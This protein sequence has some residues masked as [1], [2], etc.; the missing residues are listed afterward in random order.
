MSYE[1]TKTIRGRDYRYKVESYRDPQTGK[2]RNRWHYLGKGHGEAPPRRRAQAGETRAKL[3]AALERL[4][5]REPWSDVT[6]L[7]IAAEAG[8]TAATLYRY[9]KS[10]D[11][12]LQAC[13]A[14]AND[15]LDR[16]LAQLHDVASDVDAERARLRA[17][18]IA[19]AKN[20]PGSAVLL[21]LSSSSTST[22]VGRDRNL[23]RRRGFERYFEVLAQRGF[24]ATT[25]A[26]RARL[27]SALTFFA[28]AF[29]Y[30]VV[31]ARTQMGDD[32][33]D[34]LADAIERLVFG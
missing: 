18:T 1:V 26:E 27:A 19:L 13:G 22:A 16:H 17:W 34:A 9:F 4:L 8:V 32:E 6:A 14:D 7:D 3:I 25:P 30:R 28:Q 31:R 33:Y 2:V 10:R 23:L 29:S 15:Q 21:A 20:P 24:I 11:E 12:V 5:G